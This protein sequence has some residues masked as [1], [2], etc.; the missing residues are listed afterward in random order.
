MCFFFLLAKDQLRFVRDLQQ[1]STKT[2]F[3]GSYSASSVRTSTF[4]CYC[5]FSVTLYFKIEFFSLIGKSIILNFK[6]NVG[7]GQ[8]QV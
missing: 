2:K 3:F 8:W 7:S 4:N 5:H 6:L 1:P